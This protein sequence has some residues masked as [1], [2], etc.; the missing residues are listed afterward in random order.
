MVVEKLQSE[1][2]GTQKA[3]QAAL[4]DGGS[5]KSE[6]KRFEAECKVAETR[7]H[8]LDHV[9][10]NDSAALQAFVQG[11]DVDM[12]CQPLRVDSLAA[13]EDTE[14]AVPQS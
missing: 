3:L 4:D 5:K 7:L 9:L 1:L 6:N 2:Q 11:F 8:A 12:G 10:A 14:I 13:S